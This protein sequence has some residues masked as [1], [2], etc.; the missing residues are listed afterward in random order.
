MIIIIVIF[1]DK[2]IALLSAECVSESRCFCSHESF[3]HQRY[4]CSPKW[5]LFKRDLCSTDISLSCLAHLARED[6]GLSTV[7]R[8]FVHYTVYKIN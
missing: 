8:S 4:L 3:V 2:S 1:K 6:V 7:E 5:Y